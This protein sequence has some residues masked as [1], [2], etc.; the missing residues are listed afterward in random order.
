MDLEKSRYFEYSML[1]IKKKRDK[2]DDDECVNRYSDV[3]QNKEEAISYNNKLYFQALF[4][5]IFGFYPGGYIVREDGWHMWVKNLKKSP[6]DIIAPII[7]NA[8]IIIDEYNNKNT[9]NGPDE[10]D[11][12]TQIK[13]DIQK[14]MNDYIGMINMRFYNF[15]NNF[16]FVRKYITYDFIQTKAKEIIENSKNGIDVKTII[17]AQSENEAGFIYKY[18]NQK[19]DDVNYG[20]NK[21]LCV[22][23]NVYFLVFLEIVNMTYIASHDISIYGKNSAVTNTVC[24]HKFKKRIREILRKSFPSKFKFKSDK[25]MT[26]F[27]KDFTNRFFIEYAF[28]YN[29]KFY[30]VATV[31]AWKHEGSIKPDGYTDL[32]NNLGPEPPLDLSKSPA[33][34]YDLATKNKLVAYSIAQTVEE[35]AANSSQ[36]GRKRT[37]RHYKTHIKKRKP[38]KKGRK[39]RKHRKTRK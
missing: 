9:E 15:T 21:K 23:S 17:K 35:N 10:N 4:Y 12:N 19:E 6:T 29:S 5:D 22:H 31:D 8:K 28:N 18:S 3:I 26:E 2:S 38:I 30:D 37:R 14:Y 1:E 36:G 11:C 39:T 13:E 16:F 34:V 24:R 20:Y 25:Y 32:G 27:S 33:P 7:N